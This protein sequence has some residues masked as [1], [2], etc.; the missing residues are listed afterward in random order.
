MKSVKSTHPDPMRDTISLVVM[1]SL[2][3]SDLEFTMRL[4]GKRIAASS[5]RRPGFIPE[6]FGLPAAVWEHVRA[7]RD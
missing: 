5:A 7:L 6:V 2:H 1:N 3:A 4:V